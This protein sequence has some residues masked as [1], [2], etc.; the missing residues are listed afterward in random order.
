MLIEHRNKYRLHTRQA[1]KDAHIVAVR[2][3]RLKGCQVE[4]DV[5]PT[6]QYRKHQKVEI[7]RV[8]IKH[9]DEVKEREEEYPNDVDE[10]PVQSEVFYC[11][12]VAFRVTPF[13]S[14]G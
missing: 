2:Y 3:S 4:F 14:V 13:E 12:V 11:I 7:C 8:Q 9:L 5:S 10:V 1:E 6:H